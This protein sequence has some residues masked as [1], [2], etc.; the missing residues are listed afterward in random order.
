MKRTMITFATLIALAL[1]LAAYAQHDHGMH[2]SPKPKTASTVDE[3]DHIF[4]SYEEAR[5]ALLKQSLRD[6]KTA[7]THISV[8]AHSADQHK[9]AELAADL[10]KAADIT[11]ARAGF[12]KLS[13]EVIKY[14]ETRC[15]GDKPVVVYCS[16]EKKS[17]LQPGGEIGNP[18]VTAAMRK[19]GEVKEN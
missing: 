8:A 1:P 17:W 5:Q 9:I 13:D 2:S 11:T 16:M 7:A 18:Y 3:K 4:I 19:C 6:L 12:A 10:E 14:R 15:C